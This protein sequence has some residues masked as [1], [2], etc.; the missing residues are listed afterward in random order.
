ML[1]ADLTVVIVLRAVSAPMLKSDPGTL[2]ETV[3]GITTMGMHNSSYFC[4]ACTSSK[5]PENACVVK[6]TNYWFSACIRR[7]LHLGNIALG[8]WM[9]NL[10]VTHLK[11]SYNDQ[12]VNVELG[13]V[14][15]D[16]FYVLCWKSS[17]K[18]RKWSIERTSQI[19][20]DNSLTKRHMELGMV[21]F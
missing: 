8:W 4:L 16:V 20:Y 11:T 15:A 19:E 2:F 13:N 10:H 9:E 5:P 7:E 18:V 1:V 3:A 14:Q 12:S 17:A 21:T 6:K